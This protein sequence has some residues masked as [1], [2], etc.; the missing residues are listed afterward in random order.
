M[1]HMHPNPGLMLDAYFEK[2]LNSHLVLMVIRCISS[3]RN[4]RGIGIARASYWNDC[5]VARH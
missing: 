1:P 5:T 4:I 3:L 2:A